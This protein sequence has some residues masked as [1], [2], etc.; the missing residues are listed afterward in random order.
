MTGLGNAEE[1]FL[2]LEEVCYRLEISFQTLQ[3]MVQ[4]GRIATTRVG[5]HAVRITESELWRYLGID[6]YVSLP[7]R[8]RNGRQ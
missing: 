2:R 5:E 1:R 3:K 7:V 8:K 4:D 6:R